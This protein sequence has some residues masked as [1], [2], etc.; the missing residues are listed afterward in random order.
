MF[1]VV[2]IQGHQY[3]VQKGLKLELEKIDEAEGKDLNFTKILLV[4]EGSS[5][6]I[7]DPYVVGAKVKARLVQ[8]YKGKKIRVFK[9]KAKKRFMVNKGHRQQYTQIEITEIKS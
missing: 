1:A 7:G 6:K 9:K 2:D 5:V 8:Q 3:K 4:G